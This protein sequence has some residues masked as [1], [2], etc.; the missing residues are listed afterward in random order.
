M[1]GEEPDLLFGSPAIGD[2]EHRSLDPS[3][4]I[5]VGDAPRTHV[6]DP[7]A[8]PHRDAE[9]DLDRGSVPGAPRQMVFQLV[10]IGVHE[11]VDEV[12]QRAA[13]VPA[14]S[15]KVRELDRP[16]DEPALEIGA[17]IAEVR[18]ALHVAQP[19]LAAAQAIEGL[20]EEARDV[21]ELVRAR[22]M[23]PDVEIAAAD[24]L[25]GPLGARR[26]RA[27]SPEPTSA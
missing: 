16:V 20:V 14:E 15:Q 7:L 25:G 19:L 6:D 3:R 17:P 8:R 24:S 9:V 1:V 26:S 4:S 5:G 22:G 27:G 18:D 10:A 2:I 23:D 12:G 21:A 11:A 13:S